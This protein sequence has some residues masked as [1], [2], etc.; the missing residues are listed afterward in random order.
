[1]HLL[2]RL[3]GHRGH[4]DLDDLQERRHRE[5]QMLEHCLGVGYRSP[6][7][8]GEERHLDEVLQDGGHRP[9]LGGLL[10]RRGEE[11]HLDVGLGPFL[12]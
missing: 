2:F 8:L 4:Q 3:R 1:M 6:H 12:D 5:H 7:Q 9:D 10:H 11:R